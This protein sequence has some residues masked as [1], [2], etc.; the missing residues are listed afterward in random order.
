VNVRDDIAL[1]VEFLTTAQVAAR[2]QWSV[3]TLRAKVAA[4]VFVESM[5]FFQ[6]PGCRP[7]WKWSAVVAWLEGR[8]ARRGAPARLHPTTRGRRRVYAA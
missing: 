3:R 2:L 1:P 8:E 7:R 6:R 4:G 5:H